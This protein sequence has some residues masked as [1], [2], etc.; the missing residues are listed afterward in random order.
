MLKAGLFN[1][2]YRSDAA[3]HFWY[4]RQREVDT[5]GKYTQDVWQG[6]R[7]RECRSHLESDIAWGM[8]FQRVRLVGR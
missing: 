5:D 1:D 6:N 2:G 8:G 4:L 7:N 3:H